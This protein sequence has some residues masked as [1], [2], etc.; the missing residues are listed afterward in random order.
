[1]SV[2]LK[3]TPW[4]RRLFYGIGLASLLAGYQLLFFDPALAEMPKEQSDSIL[5]RPQSLAVDL[6]AGSTPTPT[7]NP[8]CKFCDVNGDGVVNIL[9]VTL[10]SQHWGETGAPGW[11][12]EDINRD[13]VVNILDITALTSCMGQVV[14]PGATNTTAPP[15]SSTPIPTS[16]GTSIPTATHTP[17]PPTSTLTGTWTETPSRTATSTPVPPTVTGTPPTSTNTPPVP[18]TPTPTASRSPTFTPTPDVSMSVSPANL[19][20][21]GVGSA[22]NLD[23]LISSNAPTRSAQVGF[24]FNPAVLSCSQVVEGTFYSSWAAQNGGSTLMFP[25]PSVNNT[26]GVI[27]TGGVTVLGAQGTPDPVTGGVG[28]ATGD[29]IFLT[30]Q[31]TAIATGVS[32]IT[33]TNGVVSNDNPQFSAAYPATF[34]NGVVFVGVTPTV[35]LHAAPTTTSTATLNFTPTP[36]LP[37]TSTP[38]F[39][40]SI[41]ATPTFTPTPD[42]SMSV[43]PANLV[44]SGSGSAVNLDI[45]ISSNAPTRS[46]Q[47]GFTFNPAVLSCSQVVEG[48]FYSSWAGPNGGSTQTNLPAAIDNTTGVIATVDLSINGAQGTPDP[49]TGGVGGATGSGIFLTL[50][51]TAI[52]TGVS[53]ITLTKGVVSN[54]NP[55]PAAYP[56]MITSGMVF[57]GVTPTATLPATVTPTPYPTPT[58]L[59]TDT[60]TVQAGTLS[61]NPANPLVLPNQAFTVDL[62]LNINQP[63][64]GTQFSASFDKTIL[65]CDSIVEGPFYKSW[66]AANHVTDSLFPVPGCDNTHGVITLG[67][68]SIL[69]ETTDGSGPSGSGT[70]FTLH[71]TALA[72]G[73]TGITLSSVLVS[74]AALSGT[75]PLAVA[76]SGATVTVSNSAPT[77]TLTLTPTLTPTQ[78]PTPTPSYTQ[79]PTPTSSLTYTSGPTNTPAP[80]ATNTAFIEPASTKTAYALTQGAA[81]QANASLSVS[82]TL[83][84]LDSAGGTFSLDIVVTTDKPS[85]GAQTQVTFNPA[86]LQCQSISEGNFY[87]DWATQNGGSTLVIPNPTCDNTNGKTSP[88][89]ISILGAATPDAQGNGGGPTGSGVFFTINFTAQS[90]GSTNI[91]LISSNSYLATNLAGGHTYTLA[92][93]NGAVYIGVTPNPTQAAALATS[94]PFTNGTP[95]TPTP[96]LAAINLSPTPTGT[97]GPGGSGTTGGSDSPLAAGPAIGFDL[98][99]KLDSQGVLT[100]DVE[101]QSPDGSVLMNLPKGVQ[102]LTLDNHRLPQITFAPLSGLAKDLCSF[103]TLDLNYQLGPEGANFNQPV[104]LTFHYDPSKLPKNANENKLTIISYDPVKKSCSSLKSQV[105]RKSKTVSAR[106]SHL[107][108][109]ALVLRKPLLSQMLLIVGVILLVLLIGAGIM[110]YLRGRR[111]SGLAWIPEWAKRLAHSI[112]PSRKAGSGAGPNR[113]D[114]PPAAADQPERP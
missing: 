81:I 55:V 1:L 110:W 25:S 107:S 105:D 10:V 65:H 85:L 91:D 45:L 41:T 84:Q 79:S 18:S 71:F 63:S 59:P 64:W 62:L 92:L 112:L 57:V 89:G 82:P 80:A 72:V 90:V 99:D 54:D 4:V 86:V 52:A 38:T 5:Q 14:G 101:L 103:T 15:S 2:L 76:V 39:V 113:P 100:Q 88:L 74:N 93:N 36:T 69:G 37:S 96:T 42:V 94:T 60:A 28:G 114:E 77:L 34:T 75:S 98:L 73:N 24:T 6:Q 50:Q 8:A 51:C 13:G 21:S 70:L 27:T 33:L 47:V 26:T 9:D 22:V 67:A 46:A 12:P 109:Y 66:A 40:A 104:T 16:T 17:P 58:P 49:V 68:S 31:C 43:S 7:Y 35:T 19:V 56:A 111:R 95:Q 78:T 48:T 106:I 83:K 20:I 108:I 61:M 102:A 11:I 23:I 30:L 32:P 3:G 97:G 53:P 87:K 29:G 44:V